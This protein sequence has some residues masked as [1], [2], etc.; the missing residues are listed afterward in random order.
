MFVVLNGI[1]SSEEKIKVHESERRQSLFSGGEARACWEPPN[2]SRTP[3][4]GGTVNSDHSS[5]Q[6]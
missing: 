3:T 5:R 4:Y 6:V 1:K 2:N